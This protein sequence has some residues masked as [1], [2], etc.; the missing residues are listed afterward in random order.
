MVLGWLPVGDEAPLCATGA[1]CSVDERR[2]VEGVPKRD[3]PARAQRKPSLEHIIRRR[4]VVFREEPRA[5]WGVSSEAWEEVEEARGGD[6]RARTPEFPTLG[7]QTGRME[8]RDQALRTPWWPGR[9]LRRGLELALAATA[10]V[11]FAVMAVGIPS[12]LG[13]E[14]GRAADAGL[15]KALFIGYLFVGGLVP[16][17]LLVEFV[18]RSPWLELMWACL[19]A[20]ALVSLYLWFSGGWLAFS[21]LLVG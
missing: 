18:G 17:A 14:E 15:A 13:T 5:A 21:G 11:F 20:L 19:G 10:I 6:R 9:G 2:K 12:W 1:R 3:A 7:S 16:P 4:A 8:M